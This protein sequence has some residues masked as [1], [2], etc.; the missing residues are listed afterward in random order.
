MDSALDGRGMV[1]VAYNATRNELLGH[2][3]RGAVHIV[4][5]SAIEPETPF[6]EEQLKAKV[7]EINFLRIF[8]R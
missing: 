2:P 5:D 8:E 4:L 6:V 3:R 1:G 7:W